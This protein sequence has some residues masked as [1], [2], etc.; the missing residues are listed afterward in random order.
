MRLT[1]TLVAASTICVGVSIAQ[2]PVG[3]GPNTPFNDQV[4]VHEE[5]DGTIVA[6]DQNGTFAFLSWSEY[7]N[8]RFFA[9]NQMRCGKDWLR[10]PPVGNDPAGSTSDCTMNTTNPA[11]E[12]DPGVAKYCI[13]VVVHVIEHSNGNG[14]ISDSKVSSQIDILNEDFLAIAG[15]NG[16]P[17]TDVQ[18]EF[19]LATVDPQG[20]ATN[21][22]T[23]HVNNSWYNDNGN[24]QS[25]I[26]WDT[27]RYLNLYTNTASGYLGYAYMPNGGGVVC[28]DFDGCVIHWTAFGRNS[29][30]GPPYNQGRTA[31][32]EVGHYLGLFHTFDGGCGNNN[33]NNSGDLICDTNKESDP[34]W[35]CPG[36]PNSCSS[37]D[38]FHNYMDYTDDLCM[39]E[40]TPEQARRVRCTVENWR[41]QLYDTCGGGG[42]DILFD[43]DFESGNYSAGGWTT[44]HS[45]RCVVR[46]KA[47]N[48]GNYG[49]R[50]K[51]GGQGTGACQLGTDETWIVSP[52]FSTAGYSSVLLNMNSHFRKQEIGCEYMDC[53]YSVNG[54]AWVSFAQIEQHAWGSYS[55][56]LPAGAAGVGNLRLRFITNAKGSKERAE[57]DNLVVYG[58]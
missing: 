52:S 46:A 43:D 34:V 4:S 1:L 29:S 31:T 25:Q 12:Y 20:N 50:L 24:Y 38:P 56:P 30:G 18:V 45:G 17:G 51:K 22:I 7:F 5:E 3:P 2:Q 44:S 48:S 27:C 10:H 23:R 41:P 55:L 32:H 57:I 35:G 37:Q 42:S 36:N 28:Q 15:T 8:S 13:P 47:A 54:G 49:A 39:W 16:A 6:S 26:N 9:Q 33:C 19:Y 58:S 40:F 14:F 11:N 21:G 53:Q